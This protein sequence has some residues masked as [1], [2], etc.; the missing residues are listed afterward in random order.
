MSYPSRLAVELQT[1][2]PALP[3][4]VINRGVNGEESREM[5]ARFDRDV[6]AENPDLVIWQIGSN[7]VLRDRPLSEANE[8]LREG[9]S[10][11]VRRVPTSFS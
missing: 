11:C 8:S 7:S 4:N 2:F 9:S 6:F 3:I 1:L 10:A 5:I